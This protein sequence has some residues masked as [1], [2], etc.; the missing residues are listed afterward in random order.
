MDLWRGIQTGPQGGIR[1]HHVAAIGQADLI[2]KDEELA[3]ALRPR[4]MRCDV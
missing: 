2:V 4:W 3:M 1:F